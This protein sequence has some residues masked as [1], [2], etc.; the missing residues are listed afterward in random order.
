[1]GLL[2]SNTWLF[3]LIEIGKIARNT[4]KHN[5]DYINH[6]SLYLFF[7]HLQ[8]TH[9]PYNYTHTYA[10]AHTYSHK[11]IHTLPFSRFFSFFLSLPI[12]FCPL[13]LVPYHSFSYGLL[14]PTHP[15]YSNSYTTH[16]PSRM[17]ICHFDRKTSGGLY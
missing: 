16:I 6:I 12:F 10:F 5:S 15:A 8:H 2:T 4:L 1:M 11:A 9:T 14:F 3:S 17:A 13:P 7:F